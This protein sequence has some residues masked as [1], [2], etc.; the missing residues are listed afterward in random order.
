M[1]V[2]VITWHTHLSKLTQT[3]HLKYVLLLYVSYISIISL[4]FKNKIHLYILILSVQK[5]KLKIIKQ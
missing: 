1:I 3:V 2:A 4:I 5:D